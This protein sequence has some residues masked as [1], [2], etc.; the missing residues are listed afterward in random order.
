MR[1]PVAL[2]LIDSGKTLLA[3][4]RRGGS[5]SVI[6]ARARKVVA[7]YDVGR[8]LAD[9]AVLPGDQYLLAVDQAAN[10]VLLI[11]E[12]DRKI[13]VVDRIKVSPDPVRLVLAAD[14]S[15]GMVASLWSR[16]LTFF[17]LSRGVSSD[18]EPALSI[19]GTLD[20]SFCPREQA[21][22]A[23]GSKLIVAD[24]FGGRLG[25]DRYEAAIY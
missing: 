6:D 3:A 8:G 11:D 19:I 20:L 4:N 10:E 12:R 16:R 5:L 21:V 18:L 25:G 14:G 2:A 24:A 9:L 13:R 22:T 7:E 17:G 23:D 15:F 1:H